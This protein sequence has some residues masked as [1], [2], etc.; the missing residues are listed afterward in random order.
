VPM[1]RAI[2]TIVACALLVAACEVSRSPGGD[3][4]PAPSA[5]LGDPCAML[6]MAQVGS[7]INF[8]VNTQTVA[9]AGRS[10]SWTFAD[11]NNMVAFNTAR[12][13][14]I[15]LAT[16]SAMRAATDSGTTITPVASLGDAAFSLVSGQGTS[17]NVEKGSRAFTVAVSGSAYT[18]A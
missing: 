15:D 1:K 18:P 4:S 3:T 17:L 7:A 9:D 10:C 11:P 2:V 6:T 8:T 14:L 5:A 13:T 12:L 16:F